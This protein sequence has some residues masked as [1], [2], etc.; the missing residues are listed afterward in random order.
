MDC[1]QKNKNENIVIFYANNTSLD[2]LKVY[3][4]VSIT[5]S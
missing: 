4:Q 3:Y 1:I 5:L 2:T